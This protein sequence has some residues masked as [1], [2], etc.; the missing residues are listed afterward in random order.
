MSST[1]N[2]FVHAICKRLKKCSCKKGDVLVPLGDFKP[3]TIIIIILSFLFVNVVSEATMKQSQRVG[4][5][6]GLWTLDWTHG[7]D[8]ELKFGLGFGQKQH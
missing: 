7:L 4:A 8:C 6:A 3:L 1:V 5:K 2:V